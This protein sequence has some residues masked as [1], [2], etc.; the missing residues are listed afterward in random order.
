MPPKKSLTVSLTQAYALY[1]LALPSLDKNYPGLWVGLVEH[2]LAGRWTDFNAR[3]EWIMTCYGNDKM[4]ILK[5]IFVALL[6]E[7]IKRYW[8]ITKVVSAGPLKLKV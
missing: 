1:K 7:G 5:G 2:A 8:K 6:G 4:Q 3:L